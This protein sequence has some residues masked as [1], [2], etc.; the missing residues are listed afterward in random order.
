[1]KLA[2]ASICTPCACVLECLL[3]ADLSKWQPDVALNYSPALSVL[4]FDS[5][6][7]AHGSKFGS[8]A[9][10]GFSDGV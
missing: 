1:M 2:A 10:P 8:P 4:G 3:Q 6:E 7:A 9:L 5:C